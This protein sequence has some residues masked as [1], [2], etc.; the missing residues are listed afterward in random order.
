MSTWLPPQ[1]YCHMYMLG[2]SNELGAWQREEVNPVYLQ[3]WFVTLCPE[4]LFILNETNIYAH[5]NIHSNIKES[6]YAFLGAGH[7]MQMKEGQRSDKASWLST[8]LCLKAAFICLLISSKCHLS[9]M[10]LQFWWAVCPL[11]LMSDSARVATK[12]PFK[13]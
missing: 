9:A 4:I 13:S 6:V 8:L 5:V 7:S 3:S 11:T 12:G 10:I 1:L 2:L